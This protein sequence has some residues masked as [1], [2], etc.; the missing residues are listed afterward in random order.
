MSKAKSKLRIREW[1][2][3]VIKDAPDNP[4]IG[5]GVIAFVVRCVSGKRRAAVEESHTKDLLA[6][7]MTMGEIFMMRRD[8]ELRMQ[9]EN[10][11]RKSQ[12]LPATD[13]TVDVNK[14]PDEQRARAYPP[15][16]V[17]RQ[18]IK[19]ITMEDG[20]V[21]MPLPDDFENNLEFDAETLMS[22]EALRRNRFIKLTNAE[23]GNE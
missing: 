2:F 7:G 15:H 16:V 19:S 21:V 11:R 10:E 4:L 18:C 22:L 1:S 14:V 8:E 12:G 5:M 9:R 6:Q 20:S 17:I 23:K 3:D 13:G